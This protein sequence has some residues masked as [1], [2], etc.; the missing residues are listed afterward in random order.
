MVKFYIGLVK[1]C[2]PSAYILVRRF[3]VGKGSRKYD[4]SY[5]L[6][7]CCDWTLEN[8]FQKTSTSKILPWSFAIL[9]P[10]RNQ[11]TGFDQNKVVSN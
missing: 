7:I 6:N 9:R 11:L 8:D 4:D 10:I 1:F 3:Q 2:M 5:S